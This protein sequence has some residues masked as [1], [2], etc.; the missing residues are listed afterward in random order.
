MPTSSIH[1]AVTAHALVSVGP[2]PPPGPPRYGAVR[3]TSPTANT[4]APGMMCPSADT[5]RHRTV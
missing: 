3:G 2:V 5:T 1:R 4:V